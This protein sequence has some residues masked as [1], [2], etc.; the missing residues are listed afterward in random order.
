MKKILTIAVLTIFTLSAFAQTS[1]IQVNGQAEVSV[2]PEI[3]VF[4]YNITAQSKSYDEALNELNRRVD[5]L[6]ADLKKAGFDSEA[7]KTSQFSIR[8]DKIYDRGQIKG[9]EFV[10]SQ[11]L[12]VKFDY[13][14]KKLLKVLNGT[15]SSSSAAN[16]SISFELSNEQKQAAEKSLMVAAM[17]DARMKAETLSGVEGYSILG[18]KEIMHHSAPSR[19]LAR[20]MEFDMAMSESKVASSYQPNDMS[21]TDQ[22]TVVYLLERN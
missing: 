18:V 16:L 11:S 15:T 9:E 17:K 5:A 2:L 10:A 19:P 12:V 3:A 20:T 14:M 13:N 8:K 22:V 1:T 6:S 4:N 7:I 21:I